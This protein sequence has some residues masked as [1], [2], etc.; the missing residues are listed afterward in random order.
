[1]KMD[2]KKLQELKAGD[3][4]TVITL[5][6]YQ[7][8][9]VAAGIKI[10]PRTEVTLPLNGFIMDQ[11]VLGNLVLS[12]DENAPEATGEAL[13]AEDAH[14]RSDTQ[15][16][17]SKPTEDAFGPSNAD[18]EATRQVRVE[19]Y[20]SGE[21]APRHGTSTTPSAAK[22]EVS[23]GDRSGG[24]KGTSKAKKSAASDSE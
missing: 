11:L 21:S 14:Y 16:S 6:D 2:N 10:P 7:L 12:D 5:G 18:A 15:A 19:Q 22:D 23:Q 20:R 3:E 4:V 8:I 17:R 24:E 9:D 1:M 13:K